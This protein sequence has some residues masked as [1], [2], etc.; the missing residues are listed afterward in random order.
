MLLF[1]L[2]Y[3]KNA[4]SKNQ[5]VVKTKKRKRNAFVSSIILKLAK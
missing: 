4:E 1:C 5:K 3:R 2:K